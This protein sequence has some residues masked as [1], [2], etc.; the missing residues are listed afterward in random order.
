MRRPQRVFAAVALVA[1]GCGDRPATQ[2]TAI[3]VNPVSSDAGVPAAP[4]STDHESTEAPIQIGFA[5]SRLCVRADGKIYCQSSSNP[6]PPLVQD[7]LQIGGVDDAV[8]FQ[9]GRTFACVVTRRGTV[10]CTGSNQHGEL[11]VQSDIAQSDTFVEV[12]GLTKARRVTVGFATACAVLEDKSVTCWGRN[13]H[14]QTGSDTDYQP[15]ARMLVK[16][17]LVANV[18][19][20]NAAVSGE[21]TCARTLDRQ[22]MCWGAQQDQTQA[23]KTGR[24]VNERPTRVH[25]LD[26]VSALYAMESGYCALRRGEVTCWGGA[27]RLLPSTDYF[28]SG[29][30]AVPE[31][32]DVQ[33]LALADSHACALHT[34]GRVSCFG[35]PYTMALGRAKPADQ[36]K[37]Y[38]AVGPALVEKLPR[39][40]FVAA[41]GSQSCVLTTNNDVYCWGRWYTDAGTHDEVAPIPIQLR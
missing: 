14:G 3:A 10:M 29:L 30:I 21:S 19:T 37:E 41:G 4:P 18:T 31:I 24:Y 12:V 16:P 36:Q 23:M 20:D 32:K 13:E 34:D 25:D 7:K 39:A 27:R 11:G 1:I 9:G 8:D 22:V 5:M 2:P 15:A 17:S 28:G 40:R 38:E 33:Q 35:Y 6:T 26:E